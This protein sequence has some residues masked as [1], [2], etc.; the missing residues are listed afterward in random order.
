MPA[1]KEIPTFLPNK[2]IIIDKPEEFLQNNFSSANSRNMEFYNEYL[3]GRLGMLKFSST[4]L[5]GQIML[6][7]QF[8]K[9]DNTWSWIICT[10]KDI[11]K[12]DFSGLK[13]EILTPLYSTGTVDIGTGSGAYIVIGTGV[14]FVSAGIKEGDYISIGT[15][16]HYAEDT[17]YEVDTVDSATQLTL[18][19]AAASCSGSSYAIRKTFTGGTADFW[20]SRTFQDKNL[21]ESWIATN[22]I[23]TP[24]RYHGSGQVTPMTDLPTGF[25][26]AKYVEV[27]KDRLIFLNCVESGNQPQR[28]RWSAVADCADW[29]DLD[30]LDFIEGGYNI[31]GTLVWNGYHIVFRERDAM[32]GR[33]VGG[34]SIFDYESNNTCAGAW[35]PNSIL[36]NSQKIFYYGPDNRFHAWNILN[37]EVISED[38]LSYVND[39]DPNMEQLVFGY[40]IESKN[41][42]R[43]FCPH[44]DTDYMNIC[45]TYDYVNNILH[46]WEYEQDQSLCSIGEYLNSQD[47]YVDDAF[48]GD[49]YVDEQDG[50]WDARLFVD[51]APV[52]IY[53]GAD[54]YLRKADI[55]YVDDVDSL[56][57]GV[58]YQRIFESIRQNFSMPNMVKRLWKQQ[59]WL[60]QEGSGSIEISIKKDDSNNWE[61][62]ENTISLVDS[63]RDIIK[64]NITWDKHAENFKTRV[65]AYNHFS[66]LGWINYIFAKGGTNR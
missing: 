48:W 52:L 36:S 46:I 21:G 8:W 22:G 40:E 64:K 38:I 39:F 55:G 47:L 2:G 61:G 45:I 50:F 15:G 31:T 32:V 42:M 58:P 33:W 24:V 20:F 65:S 12:F 25:I 26:S 41:Q 44:G 5:S 37:D 43:W 62:E 23:D 17:W 9:Y 16:T 14:D 10:N 35:A 19:T 34:T 60:Q 1:L 49:L 30:Y 4:Q 18:K 51:G 3:R 11:Y 29:D 66:M 59:H 57:T 27:Y 56:G 28:E 6:I 7:D 54:G 63:S 53:G 13:F